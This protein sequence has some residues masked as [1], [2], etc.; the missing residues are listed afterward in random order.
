MEVTYEIYEKRFQF[1]VPLKNPTKAYSYRH[2]RNTMFFH[3]RIHFV[4]VKP[5]VGDWDAFI[6]IFTK[7]PR[8][9]TVHVKRFAIEEKKEQIIGLLKRT[10]LLFIRYSFHLS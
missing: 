7:D 5:V 2:K 4:E 9:E 1:Y 6:S 10:F 8:C 3:I